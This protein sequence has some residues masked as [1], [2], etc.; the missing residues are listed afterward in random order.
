VDAAAVAWLDSDRHE[1]L[2]ALEESGLVVMSVGRRGRFVTDRGALKGLT[3]H[4][5]Y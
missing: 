3:A 1:L 5:L 2:V 4:C